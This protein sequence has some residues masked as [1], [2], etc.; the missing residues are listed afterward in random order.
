MDNYEMYRQLCCEE[1]CTKRSSYNFKGERKS[2]Y[3]S[4]HKHDG[5][6]NVKIELVSNHSVQNSQILI[7]REKVKLYI[8]QHTSKMVWSI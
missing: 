6:V 8:V 2:I 7:S 4:A 5:M 3:C 1:K